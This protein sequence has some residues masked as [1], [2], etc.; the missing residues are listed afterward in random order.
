MDGAAQRRFR[1]NPIEIAILAVV[2]GMF[3]H[4]AYT[5]VDSRESFEFA[6]LTPMVSN[7][8]SEGRSLASVS[9]AN[10]SVNVNCEANPAVPTSASR[11]RLTG[12][13][14][15]VDAGP[16]GT[17]LVK[18]GVVNQANSAN[19]TV[20]TDLDTGKFSTEYLPF[21]NGKNPIR[22]EFHYRDGKVVS[23]DVEIT[24]N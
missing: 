4:S 3:A 2:T 20:F 11:A 7:P 8:I 24:R 19:A 14:C 6:S 5:L 1:I 15:G 18:T 10:V 13:L 23:H 9:T 16:E 21:A 12:S 17:N 22:V